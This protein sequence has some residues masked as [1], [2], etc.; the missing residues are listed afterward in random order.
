MAKK[1]DKDP[2]IVL[3][4]KCKGVIG[5][6]KTG[7]AEMRCHKCKVNYHVKVEWI[8]KIIVDITDAISKT[9]P[10]SA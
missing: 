5:R 4:A 10:A 9:S 1:K 8:P 2:D 6:I 7:E 3:C